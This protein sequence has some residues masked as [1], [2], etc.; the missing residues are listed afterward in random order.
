MPFATLNNIKSKFH[1]EDTENFFYSINESGSIILQK[2]SE[3]ELLSEDSLKKIYDEEPDGLW[4]SC[5][6]D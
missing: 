1:L 5:L 2:V 4:E 3:Y 6:N